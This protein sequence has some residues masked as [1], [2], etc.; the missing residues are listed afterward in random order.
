MTSEQ[1][2]R[3]GV[4]DDV[5]DHAARLISAAD[6]RL[7]RLSIR[8]G[9]IAV[10]LEWSPAA[11]PAAPAAEPAGALAAP[12]RHGLAGPEPCEATGRD[13][14]HHVCAEMVGTFYTA[15]EPGAEPFVA[16]GDEVRAGQQIAILEVMKLMTPVGADR[17]GRVVEVLVPDGTSVEFGTG[18][19][20]L[21]T[22][23]QA[24]GTPG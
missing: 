6:P 9:D 19:I 2:E 22:S 15:P 14:L 10:E 12:A 18:L 21:D 24:I 11:A 8:T 7:H 16:V 1:A 17:A 3:N 23:V 4:L 5:C 20:A 13:A